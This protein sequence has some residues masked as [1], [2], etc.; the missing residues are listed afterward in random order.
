MK[1]WLFLLVVLLSGC[2]DPCEPRRDCVKKKTTHV[3]IPMRVGNMT[4]MRMQ[5]ITKCVEYGDWYI[6]KEC[7]KESE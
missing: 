4:V 6:S 5:P 1:V 2:K 7:K 3:L